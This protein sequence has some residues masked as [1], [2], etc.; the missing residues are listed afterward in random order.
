MEVVLVIQRNRQARQAQYD[1]QEPAFIMVFYGLYVK[2]V[3]L[4]RANILAKRSFVE[5]EHHSIRRM[6]FVITHL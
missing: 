1:N 4:F 6:V 2:Y 5:Q 3:L